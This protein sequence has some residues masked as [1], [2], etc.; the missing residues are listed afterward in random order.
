MPVDNY[1]EGTGFLLISKN[2]KGK[3]VNSSF[4]LA[5]EIYPKIIIP[6]PLFTKT[7]LQTDIIVGDTII[8]YSVDEDQ[9][10]IYHIDNIT[11]Q[12]RKSANI[13]EMSRT[14]NNFIGEETLKKCTLP[15]KQFYSY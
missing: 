15:A 6:N 9:Q 5:E 1:P 2:N 14:P 13:Q 12:S 11:V 4:T 8:R 10:R 7:R 3:T